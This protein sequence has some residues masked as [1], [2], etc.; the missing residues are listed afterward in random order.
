MRLFVLLCCLSSLSIT[1]LTAFQTQYGRYGLAVKP[2]Y[3]IA[4][5]MPPAK[6][7]KSLFEWTMDSLS[8]HMSITAQFI[9]H[10]VLECAKHARALG[11]HIAQLPFKKTAQQLHIVND[12]TV[13]PRDLARV[14]YCLSLPLADWWIVPLMKKRFGLT[15]KQINLFKNWQAQGKSVATEVAA[16]RTFIERYRLHKILQITELIAATASAYQICAHEVVK[17]VRNALQHTGTV[18][19]ERTQ[20][21]I[22]WQ[23]E[24]ASLEWV[25]ASDVHGGP[26][27]NNT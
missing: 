12:L 1:M 27:L 21:P 26:A 17:K 6:P 15:E 4:P 13:S 22:D 10:T 20:K 7:Q 5:V 3:H 19:L 25:I 18:L 8:N 2:A 11:K 24:T 9:G 16:W 23:Q 14:Q